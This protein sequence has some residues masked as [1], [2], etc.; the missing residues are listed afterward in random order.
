[1]LPALRGP[2]VFV[3]HIIQVCP[4][5]RWLICP[6]LYLYGGG[7]GVPFSNFSGF[8]QVVS[9]SEAT[10]VNY[11]WGMGCSGLFPVSFVRRFVFWV[12]L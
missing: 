4:S 12:A 5:N 2:A 7:E 11:V 10:L 6:G 1:M 9:L 3:P 8:L